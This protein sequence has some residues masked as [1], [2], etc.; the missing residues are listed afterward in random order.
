MKRVPVKIGDVIVLVLF[1]TV[2]VISFL[3]I[4]NNSQ[5]K[6]VLIITAEEATYIY[7]LDKDGT[8]TIAGLIGTSTIQ[9]Q[10]GQAF[11]VD[12]P[13]PNK[14]C[15]QAGH[16]SHN[17]EWNAC[18]PNDIFIRIQQDESDIDASAF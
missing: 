8:Y 5:A 18:L 7:P 15:V 11:F 1:A 6:P 17:G 10:D 12:S 16:I 9:V 13:C 2:T 14:T 3:R 4:R